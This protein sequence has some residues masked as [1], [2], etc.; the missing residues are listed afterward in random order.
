LNEHQ[1]KLTFTARVV[2][3]R[4]VDLGDPRAVEI[5]RLTDEELFGNWLL[6]PSPTR[7]ENLGSAIAN[8]RAIAA[9]RY[10]S[11]ATHKLNR[12]GWNVA[13]FRAALESPDRV[14]ILGGLGNPLEVLPGSE[15]Y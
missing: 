4:V 10:P 6:K 3:R 9:I 12:E 2:L 15:F 11:A 1:P 13:I 7:L 5:L 8:Q 14:E